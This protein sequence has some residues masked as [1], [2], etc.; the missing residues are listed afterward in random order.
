MY[1][2]IMRGLG[3][4]IQKLRK[5]RRLTLL[6][7]AKKTR[8]DMATLSRIENGKMTGTLDSHVQIAEALGV[9]L[10]ELYEQ[11][12]DKVYEAKDEKVRKRIETYSHS[13][14]A[15]AELL[16][17]GVLQ[18]KMM[19]IVLKLKIGGHTAA[20]EYSGITERFIYV[21][22][23]ALEIH[24]GKATKTLKQGESLYFDA[25]LPHSFRNPLKSETEALSVLTPS[26]L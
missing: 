10:P 1:D 11:V 17:T 22:K 23:G 12:I 26:S 3:E 7:I 21:T 5:A 15:V 13:S 20:E 19:P 16:T 9:R 25:S 18:K 14:G 24:L 8:I 6:E 4:R 2:N